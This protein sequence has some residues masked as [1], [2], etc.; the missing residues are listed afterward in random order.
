MGGLYLILRLQN[1]PHGTG[2]RPFVEERRRTKVIPHLFEERSLVQLVVAVLI[3][4]SE[5]WNKKWFSEVEQH[6]IRNLR[7]KRKLDDPEVS[8]LE[9]TTDHQPRRSAASAA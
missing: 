4:V 5:R 6:Q 9:P 7:R 2:T 1:Y 3:R 8:I